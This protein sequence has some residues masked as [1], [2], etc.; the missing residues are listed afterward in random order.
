LKFCVLKGFSMLYLK[1]HGIFE[2]KVLGLLADAFVQVL[3][4]RG[5]AG[6]YQ[7]GDCG[8]RKRF[9]LLGRLAVVRVFAFVAAVALPFGELEARILLAV[10]GAF[11]CA[12]FAAAAAA[13]AL[14]A[15]RAAGPTAWMVPE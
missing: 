3:H 5:H 4:S 8:N 10:G 12:G 13:A 11:A 2:K 7:L 1:T 14:V 15:V 9:R 6:C